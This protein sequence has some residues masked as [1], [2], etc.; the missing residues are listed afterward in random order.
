MCNILIII[1][2]VI[3]ILQTLS[4]PYFIILKAECAFSDHWLF[5]GL[6]R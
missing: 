3:I 2:I 5:N 4:V 1:I 6:V